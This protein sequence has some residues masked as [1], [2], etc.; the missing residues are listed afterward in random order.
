MVQDTWCCISYSPPEKL[1]KYSPKP[2]FPACIIPW[3]TDG[4]QELDRAAPL[5]S[6]DSSKPLICVTSWALL[7]C[8]TGVGNARDWAV[9]WMMQVFNLKRQTAVFFITDTMQKVQGGM[10]DGDRTQDH[11]RSSMSPWTFS[12]NFLIPGEHYWGAAF[13][14]ITIKSVEI[15]L[16]IK[17][18]NVKEDKDQVMRSNRSIFNW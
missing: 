12:W 11:H 14:D 18:Q 6:A 10:V 8:E 2:Y 4:K 1:A 7:P 5:F 17:W 15:D 13:S 16:K 9:T 3:I